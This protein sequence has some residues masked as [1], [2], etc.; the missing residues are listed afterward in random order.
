MSFDFHSFKVP[1]I[2]WES[3]AS[4]Y[5]DIAIDFKHPLYSE[6]L[7]DLKNYPIQIKSYY[8]VED[9]T[10]EPYCKKIDGSLESVFCRKQVAEILLRANALLNVYGLELLVLDGYRTPQTQQG[11]WNFFKNQ[12]AAKLG[13]KSCD[14]E[15]YSE[16]IKYVSDPSSFDE[17]NYNTWPTHSTGGAIDVTVQNIENKIALKMGSDFDEMTEQSHTDYFERKLRLEEIGNDNEFL[18][19]RRIL[20]WAMSSCGFINYPREYWHYDWGTQMYQ[21]HQSKLLNTAPNAAWYG[22]TRL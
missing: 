1:I 20:F 11:L 6:K 3:D 8:N 21:H 10:N 4:S 16:V 19:N 7:V 13:K 12:V 15:I 17:Y 22:F 9:G 5:R 2:D 18:K 14:R